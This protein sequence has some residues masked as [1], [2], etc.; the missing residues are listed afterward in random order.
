M[1]FYRRRRLWLLSSVSRM[2]LRVVGSV[3]TTDRVEGNVP[4]TDR[5]AP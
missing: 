1:T 4:S 5:G 3:P 2:V